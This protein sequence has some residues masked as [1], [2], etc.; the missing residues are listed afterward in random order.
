LTLSANAG[1]DR[2]AATRRDGEDPDLAE[3][4]AGRGG[5]RDRDAA[6]RPRNARPRDGLGRPLDRGTAGEPTIPDDMRMASGDAL[7]LAQRLIDDGRPFHAHEVLEAVWKAGPADQ[8][9]LWK[10]LAQLAVG[11]T[12]ARRGN[13]RGAVTLLRRGAAALRGYEGVRVVP[14][15]LDLTGARQRA[16][17]LADRI[18]QAG[19]AS[20]TEEELRLRLI[21]QPA[22]PPDESAV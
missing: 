14:A 17:E 21:A 13:G 10:G 6:G 8:R 18:E 4:L 2:D 12:H 9:G 16:D 11:L 20:V 15:G 19:L 5:G 3:S 22:V 1:P 7:L